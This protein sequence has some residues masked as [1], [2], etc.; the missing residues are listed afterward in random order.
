MVLCAGRYTLLEQGALDDLMPACERTT[1]S[2]VIGGV[3][4]SGL[5]TDPR[6][7]AHYNYV[8]A[9]IE[10][11]RR[12]QRIQTVCARFGV[13]LPAAALQFPLAPPRVSTVLLGVTTAPSSRTTCAG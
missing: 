2:V 12:A 3:F 4:N 13:P 5:L 1:A 6:E 11:I 7:G 9:P 8:K 10:V